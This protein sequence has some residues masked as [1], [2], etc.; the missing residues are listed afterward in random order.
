MTSNHQTTNLDFPIFYEFF[1]VL[2]VE[3]ENKL[4]KHWSKTGL[5]QF[6]TNEKFPFQ[7]LKLRKICSK[8]GE[9]KIGCL[10]SRIRYCFLLSFPL[11][12][13]EFRIRNSWNIV[14]SSILKVIY[15]FEIVT[16]TNYELKPIMMRFIF[17]G[18]EAELIFTRSVT[19]SEDACKEMERLLV[20][21]HY[22]FIRILNF[23]LFKN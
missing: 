12:A 10:M 11:W 9:N 15:F 21:A 19:S 14:V 23:L 4:F 7:L 18:N 20:R 16:T 13:T 17:S 8:I 5:S 1:S 6:W 2:A 3:K 22:M